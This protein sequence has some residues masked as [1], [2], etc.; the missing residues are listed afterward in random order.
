MVFPFDPTSITVISSVLSEWRK[1]GPPQVSPDQ[2]PDASIARNRIRE[3]QNEGLGL[4]SQSAKVPEDAYKNPSTMHD[5]YER[6]QAMSVDEVVS[7]HKRW[8]SVRD[9]LDSG[10]KDFGPAIA[11]ATDDK[12]QGASHKAA[13]EGITE[14]VKNAQGL[15]GSVQ[16]VSEKV[17]IIRSGIELTRPNVQKAPDHTLSSNIASWVPGPTW[18]INQHRDDQ[19]QNAAVNT[20][21][22]VFY[23]AVRETDSGVPLVPKPDNPIHQEEVGPVVRKTGGDQPKPGG[24]PGPGKNGPDGNGK[25][26]GDGK[27]KDQGTNP[28]NTKPDGT[29][30]TGTNPTNTDPTKT[31]TQ[32]TDD[33]SKTKT[34]PTSTNPTSTTPSPT[35]FDPS[36]TGLPG[37]PKTGTPNTGNPGA[38]RSSLNLPPVVTAA[39][40]ANLAAATRAGANGASGF[41]MPGAARG[42]GDDDKEHKTKDYLVNRENGEELTGLDE[43]SRVKSVPPVIGE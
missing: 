12:W 30:P 18:R 25:D 31:D 24:D 7:T 20:I 42:K 43:K 27:D 32:K 6:V 16:L 14:Y 41:G 33:P 28:D 36:K 39:N 35:T 13:S 22:N 26:K 8:E 11:K 29:N 17:K 19:Y 2:S 21:K 23:P 1:S 10:L 38:P 3:I 15:L 34:N 9:R 40:P 37:T 5:L 4:Q